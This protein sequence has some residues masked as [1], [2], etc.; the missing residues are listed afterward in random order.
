M[1]VPVAVTHVVR[2]RLGGTEEV[3]PEVMQGVSAW[4]DL[5][6]K[7]KRDTSGAEIVREDGNNGSTCVDRGRCG[8]G[9]SADDGAAD[10]YKR[11]RG[12]HAVAVKNLTFHY[13]T[14]DGRPV[15]GPPQLD[16]MSFSLEAGSCT[17]LIGANGAGK[18]T[19]LRVLGGQSMVAKDAVRVLGVPPFHTTPLISDGVL[20]YIGGTWAQ[21]VAFAGFSVPLT[22]DFPAGQMINSIGGVPPERKR[23]L[24]D[25]LDIDEEWRMHRVSDGQRRRVQ[26]AI[27]LLKPFK[28]LLLDEVT[29]DLDALARRSL[30]DFLKDEARNRGAT[31][32][33]TT[34]IFDGMEQWPDHLLF[35]AAGAVKRFAPISDF[36]MLANGETT[37]LRLVE[38]W[39]RSEKALAKIKEAERAT[40][41]AAD[42]EKP[43]FKY[44][45]N[46]GFSSGTLTTSLAGSSN[47]VLRN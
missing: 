30:L 1:P 5:A 6:G 12:E 43:G 36:P 19:L 7:K 29:V 42:E 27:G 9:V 39:L 31:I 13:Q 8:A 20:S 15:A 41:A 45:F 46:N 3:A 4:S 37:M 18:T 40:T 34:H 33:Y 2:E 35:C 10:A 24:L 11:F 32:V 44:A 16:A 25:V 14:V 47:S 21:D 22:G 28:V 38:R 17:L 23:L 26:L